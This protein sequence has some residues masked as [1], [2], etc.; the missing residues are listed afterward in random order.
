MSVKIVKE[1]E[2]IQYD[3]NLPIE[4]QL[5][6]SRQIL[7]NYEKSDIVLEKFLDEIERLI[8]KG[9]YK[10]LNIKVVNTKQMSLESKNVSEINKLINLI[11]STYKS[12]DEKLEAI[13]EFCNNRK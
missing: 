12:V 5:A 6:G 9:S 2:T 4:T 8:K 1:K 10:D 3:A 11:A 13:T 7:V